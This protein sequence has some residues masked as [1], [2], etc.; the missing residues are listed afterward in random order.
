MQLGILRNGFRLTFKNCNEGR[1]PKLIVNESSDRLHPDRLNSLKQHGKEAHK[2]SGP[3]LGV[4]TIDQMISCHH[5]TSPLLVGNGFMTSPLAL[6]TSN[7]FIFLIS[8]GNSPILQPEITRL[9]RDPSLL[10]FLGS[11]LRV[12]QSFRSSKSSS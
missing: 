4:G 10:M 11:F 12:L 8:I 7:D 5:L 6:S 2:V 1:L 3:F 9:F